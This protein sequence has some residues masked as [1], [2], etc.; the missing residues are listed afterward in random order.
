MD[1]Q[2]VLWLRNAV[3]IRR[4]LVVHLVLLPRSL[5]R[6]NIDVIPPEIG[7]LVSLKDLCAFIFHDL[8][9]HWAFTKPA[10]MIGARV[11]VTGL[12]RCGPDKT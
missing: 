6:R 7:Q 5:W 3:L 1:I 11:S 12:D 8:L 10:I 2:A 9:L 4:H